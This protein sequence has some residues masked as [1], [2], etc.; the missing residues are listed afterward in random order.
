[1]IF[2]IMGLVYMMG[3]RTGIHI[4]V[5]FWG[6]WNLGDRQPDYNDVHGW[7]HAHVERIFAKL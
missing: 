2:L 1:M 7:Y 5:L 4:A 6:R 3:Q